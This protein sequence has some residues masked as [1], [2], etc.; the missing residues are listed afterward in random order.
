MASFKIS[1]SAKK[2]LRKIHKYTVKEWGK[3][4]WTAYRKIL[5]NTFQKLAEKPEL[6]AEREDIRPGARSFLEVNKKGTEFIINKSALELSS[7]EFFIMHRKQKVRSQF[8][9]RI[10]IRI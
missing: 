2:D 4:Q 10:L 8:K 6:G 9:N 5:K 3:R 1:E 7:P